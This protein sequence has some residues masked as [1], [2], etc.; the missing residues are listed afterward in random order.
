M[1]LKS[2]LTSMLS[3][4]CQ[5]INLTAFK[6][7]PSLFIL[8][9]QFHFRHT[10]GNDA[11]HY[12]TGSTSSPQRSRIR[13]RLNPLHQLLHETRTQ[14]QE[15]RPLTNEMRRLPTAIYR[16]LA[17]HQE[18]IAISNVARRH[19]CRPVT[20]STTSDTSVSVRRQSATSR[21]PPEANQSSFVRIVP[22]MSLNLSEPSRHPVTSPI[23]ASSP[24]TVSVATQS[25]VVQ[26]EPVQAP[27]ATELV[28]LTND[29]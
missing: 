16:F 10:S 14:F 25:S 29:F 7:L 13:R 8:I 4:Q 15:I 24:S 21:Q 28:E 11:T 3:M 19:S 5:K 1:L 9:R 26:L 23:Y 20:R 27:I 12:E 22:L 17:F 6:A 18:S 2:H